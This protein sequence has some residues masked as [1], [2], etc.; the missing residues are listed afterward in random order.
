MAAMFICRSVECDAPAVTPWVLNDRPRIAGF[1]EVV[2]L[3]RP[4]MLVLADY[5]RLTITDRAGVGSVQI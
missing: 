3:C 1:H 2:L 4:H 5:G